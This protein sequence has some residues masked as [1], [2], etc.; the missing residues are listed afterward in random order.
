MSN[1]LKIDLKNPSL[2]GV[3]TKR[4]MRKYVTPWSFK[5]LINGGKGE[6]VEE[7]VLDWLVNVKKYTNI[8]KSKPQSSHDFRFK[9]SKNVLVDIRRFGF[10][11]NKEGI[12]LGYTSITKQREYSWDHK[13][14]YLEHGGYLG[15]RV[16]KEKIFLY[17][18]PAKFV[19]C[20]HS[21]SRIHIDKVT[22]WVSENKKSNVKQ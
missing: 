18:L 11:T 12:Y 16:Y 21:A 4:N 20:N 8:V 14:H 13:A 1:K 9:Q 7:I 2:V 5:R 19:L 6:F 3:I 17:Y 15:A 22:D 10:K